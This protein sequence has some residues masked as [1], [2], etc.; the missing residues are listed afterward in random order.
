MAAKIK[1]LGKKV[2]KGGRMTTRSGWK[3]V[4]EKGRDR[5]FIGTL[6]ATFNLGRK[7]IAVFNVPK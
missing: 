4:I 7:R 6:L 1:V 3:L 5:G 2:R